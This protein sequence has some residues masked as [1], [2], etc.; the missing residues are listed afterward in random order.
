MT[1]KEERVTITEWKC[2]GEITTE[3]VGKAA[4]ELDRAIL[5][6][7][8]LRYIEESGTTTPE[9]WESFKDKPTPPRNPA[10]IQA[11]MNTKTKRP[12]R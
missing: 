12:A 9:Q 7:M 3:Q 11:A 8:R 6:L 4:R 10:P 2:E 1:D 5:G